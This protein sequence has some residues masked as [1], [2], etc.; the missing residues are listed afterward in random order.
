MSRKLLVLPKYGASAA[1]FRQR[2][3]QYLP[4]I[5]REGFT[6]DRFELFDDR[7]VRRLQEGRVF[8][9]A[10]L[11]Q[12]Y[13]RRAS[14]LM[15]ANHYDA[16]WLHCENFP[17]FPAFAETVLIP[18]GTPLILDFDDAI[19]HQYD[20]HRL[21]P[22]RALLGRKL[23]GLMRRA[24]I[25][26]PGN[27]YL[28]AYAERFCKDVRVLPTVVDTERY[29]PAPSRA[30]GRAITIGW[31][32][33][34]STWAFIEPLTPIL[35]RFA[36]RA[37]VRV[38]VVG[39]GRLAGKPEG[40]EFLDWAEEREIADIQSMDIGIMPLPDEPF[41]RGKCGYK[42]IQYGA[43]G[44][45]VVASPVGVNAEIVIEGETGF[46]AGA[47][48]LF[49]AAIKRLLAD[50]GLR[51]RLG[52]AGRARVVERY[53]LAAYEARFMDAL[54]DAMAKTHPDKTA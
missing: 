22:V 33:S 23:Q 18:R 48:E 24:K 8:S 4:A 1:S 11:L 39:A 29:R 5:Q 52:E 12:A 26:T 17:Y 45:P 40:L 36:A 54:K 25:C 9:P 15:K 47:P 30:E 10:S 41:A 38:K 28:A 34:P 32:G 2:F 3:Q 19:F 49:G 37:D 44:L 14:V 7:H 21:A 31:I 35:Q 42:L 27:A 50:P 51:Q 20:S 16:I 53:S 13:A 6:V 43:C 46:L